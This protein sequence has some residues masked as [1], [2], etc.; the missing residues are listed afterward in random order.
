MARHR[1]NFDLRGQAFKRDPA[2]TFAAMRAVGP[3][4]DARIPIIGK[5]TFTT[6]YAATSELLRQP[7]RFSVDATNAG[8]AFPFG[9]R[10]LPRNLRRMA[11]G[12]LAKDGA[13]HQ[14]LRKLVDQAFN[15]R[16]VDSYR[17]RIGELTDALLD[18]LVAS[19]DGDLVGRFARALPLKV[20]CEILGLPTEDRPKFERW[21]QSTS[22]AG[23]LLDIF[24]FLPSLN[25]MTQYLEAKF[26]ERRREPRDDL[27]T[28]LVQAEAE[29][30]KLS[31]DEL[32][33]MC[34]LLFVAGH[35]TTTHLISGGVLALLQNPEQLERL[36][37]DPGLAP[38]A[39]DELLRYVCPVQMTKPRFVVEDTEFHG[40]SVKRGDAL[41][42]LLASANMDPHAFDEPQRMDLKRK[43]SRHL[44]FGDGPHYCLGWQLAKAEVET[45][46]NQLFARYP[47]VGLAVPE[48]ELRWTKRAGLRSLTHL[49]LEFR[50]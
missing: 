17:A 15:R 10:W 29:G 22:A 45:A 44:A 3:L 18:E 48:A 1:H 25:K 28:A 2:P 24:R 50:S 42:G 14:R 13:D 39:V 11:S 35:E 7:Q 9:I 37:S 8:K 47:R 6:T 34:F 41:V 27:I 21:M 40:T 46:L 30:D 32:L 4:V 5:A 31:T 20:I 19:P 23:S 43:G 36:K 16:G 26:D 12:M 33:A 38:S 49:P